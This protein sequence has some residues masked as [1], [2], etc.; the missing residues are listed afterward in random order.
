MRALIVLSLTAIVF[1]SNPCEAGMSTGPHD[2]AVRTPAAHHATMSHRRGRVHHA[3]R[4]GGP[5]AAVGA[6][7]NAIGNTIG[8]IFR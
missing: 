8:G 4:I 6:V 2:V 3:R 7:G 1:G 5:I